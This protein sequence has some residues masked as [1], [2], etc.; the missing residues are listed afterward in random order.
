M[1]ILIF[2]LDHS[3][4]ENAQFVNKIDNNVENKILKLKYNAACSD[5]V[6][7]LALLVLYKILPIAS[8]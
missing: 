7:W 1:S 4:G 5:L 8:S 3:F 2:V 6:Q